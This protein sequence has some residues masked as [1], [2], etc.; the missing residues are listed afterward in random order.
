MLK[1]LRDYLANIFKG[2]D[3]GIKSTTQAKQALDEAASDIR[4]T[5][6]GEVTGGFDE[7]TKPMEF[8][9]GKPIIGPEG[10]TQTRVFSYRP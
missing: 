8:K 4:K 2:S 7:T 3:T 1:K 9:E 10:E 5:D 6:L